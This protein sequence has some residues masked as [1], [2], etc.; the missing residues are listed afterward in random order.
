MRIT[1][2]LQCPRNASNKCSPDFKSDPSPLP[3]GT[4]TISAHVAGDTHCISMARTGFQSRSATTPPPSRLG[5][6]RQRF[7]AER[8]KLADQ[9]G[10]RG[11]APARAAFA[12]RA[13]RFVT[14]Q[15][16]HRLLDAAWPSAQ[17]PRRQKPQIEEGQLRPTFGAQQI[18]RV[19]APAAEE[20]ARAQEGAE[21]RERAFDVVA[22]ED[23]RGV[24][25]KMCGRAR[26]ERPP[27]CDQRLE[28]RAARRPDR[29]QLDQLGLAGAAP[30]T[31]MGVR[32]GVEGHRGGKARA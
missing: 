14:A 20:I 11:E 24:D 30:K 19:A 9:R 21:A 7:A 26:S 22:G 23:S 15:E 27:R 32:L 2:A 25:L 10:Q 3:G 18:E 29:D 8:T 16:P 13:R 28:A 12:K 1:F 4:N 31:C 17:E 6:K 5:S